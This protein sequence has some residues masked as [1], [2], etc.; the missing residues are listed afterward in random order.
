MIKSYSRTLIPAFVISSQMFVTVS[1]NQQID[2]D[3]SMFIGDTISCSV[4][5][6][7]GQCAFSAYTYEQPEV[8][9]P[10]QVAS[11]QEMQAP[12]EDPMFAYQPSADAFLQP[13]ASYQQASFA[14]QDPAASLQDPM[15]AYQKSTPSLTAPS[16]SA[17]AY[18]NNQA[19]LTYTQ[20]NV[21]YQKNNTSTEQVSLSAQTPSKSYQK[22]RS[23]ISAPTIS[24]FHKQTSFAR[25]SV[26]FKPYSYIRASGAVL[27]NEYDEAKTAVE[28]SNFEKATK[29]VGLRAGMM[30]NQNFGFEARLGYGIKP[31]VSSKKKTES[32]NT[33]YEYVND[34]PKTDIAQV[35]MARAV[36]SYQAIPRSTDG[37]SNPKEESSS[38]SDSSKT[39]KVDGYVA[40]MGRVQ[41]KIG[42]GG[43][44]IVPYA[45]LGVAA[46][47][48]TME[49]ESK[50]GT[51]VEEDT[52]IGLAAAAGVE[53]NLA[54][55]FVIGI[56]GS[57]LP[58]NIKTVS[59]T[60][61]YN[62]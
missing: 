39:Q 36:K 52:T 48:T 5:D 54:R 8:L 45:N 19:A 32:S 51:I 56:E 23:G 28:K 16:F 37:N 40:A 59:A 3:N 22:A 31:K 57:Y 12:Y 20:P 62:F 7:F 15:F 44:E 35:N 60:V 9:Y 13:D 58:N 10:D 53:I 17:P 43:L 29:S 25:S 34:R 50:T 14:Y 1:A 4:Y 55:N 26:K 30:M 11:F 24:A 61:G 6:L 18:V 46:V 27:F 38:G 33:S 41:A 49:T 47:K 42:G 21:A 2:I